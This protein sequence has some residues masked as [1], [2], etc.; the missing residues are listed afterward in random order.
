MVMVTVP[1]LTVIITIMIRT[2]IGKTMVKR[3]EE[4]GKG[5]EE[6]KGQGVRRK[7]YVCNASYVSRVTKKGTVMLGYLYSL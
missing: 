2:V 5:E 6:D 7:S 1:P 3:E 4:E